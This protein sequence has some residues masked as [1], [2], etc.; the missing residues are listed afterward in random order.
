MVEHFFHGVTL[1][2]ALKPECDGCRLFAESNLEEFSGLNVVLVSAEGERNNEWCD[3]DHEIIVAPE[4]LDQLDV[5]WPPYYAL[6][7]S[8]TSSVL[9]EGVVFGPRQVADE[10]R[11]YVPR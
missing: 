1:V 5:R 10:I 9:V 11:S 6:I 3:V 8:R 2:V 4:L 7:D